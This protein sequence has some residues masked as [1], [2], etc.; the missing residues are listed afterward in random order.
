MKWQRNECPSQ[1]FCWAYISIV[2]ILYYLL[3]GK[4]EP[5]AHFVHLSIIELKIARL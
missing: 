1:R 5:F 3:I 4:Y 2:S